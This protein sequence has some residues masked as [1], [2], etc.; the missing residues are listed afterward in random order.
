MRTAGIDEIDVWLTHRPWTTLYGRWLSKKP[1]K[2]VWHC[3]P[4]PVDGSSS[5]LLMPGLCRVP[6]VASNKSISVASIIAHCGCTLSCVHV[7]D[8]LTAALCSCTL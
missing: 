5:H 1:R 4:P 7:I 6:R 8:K 3:A 2:E